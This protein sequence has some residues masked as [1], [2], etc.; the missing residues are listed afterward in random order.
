MI[1]KLPCQSQYVGIFIEN[2]RIETVG[3]NNINRTFFILFVEIFV[4][5]FIFAR[6]L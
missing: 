1:E 4:F 2:I 3:P 5:Y 6:I